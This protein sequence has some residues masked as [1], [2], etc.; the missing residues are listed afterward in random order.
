MYGIKDKTTGLYLTKDGAKNFQYY[1]SDYFLSGCIYMNG[2]QEEVE[3][4]LG[5]LKRINEFFFGDDIVMCKFS[6]KMIAELTY[7]KLKEGN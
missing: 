1:F 6:E 7:R 3:K 2:S 5:D 4:L